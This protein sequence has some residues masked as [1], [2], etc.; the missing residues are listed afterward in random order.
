MITF[1]KTS[2]ERFFKC[3]QTSIHA[4]SQLEPHAAHPGRAKQTGK[5]I[6]IL[7]AVMFFVA[8]RL[9][10]QS[11]LHKMLITLLQNSSTSDSNKREPL[12]QPQVD[13]D[14]NSTRKAD[15]AKAVHRTA[16]GKERQRGD[17][18]DD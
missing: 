5:C 9:D 4:F 2:N 16:N 3:Y 8:A 17:N 7:R 15:V 14:K 6:R 18:G 1:V 11:K 13:T 12:S 10:P